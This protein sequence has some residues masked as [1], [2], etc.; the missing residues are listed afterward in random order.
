[1]NVKHETSS[2]RKQLLLI[3]FINVYIYIYTHTLYITVNMGLTVSEKSVFQTSF[4]CDGFQGN[5]FSFEKQVVTKDF[6]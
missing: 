5:L 4:G 1:M 3:P 2:C 6:T